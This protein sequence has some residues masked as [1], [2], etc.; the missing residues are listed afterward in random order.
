MHP[1]HEREVLNMTLAASGNETHRDKKR[2]ALLRSGGAT[3]LRIRAA[4][5]TLAHGGKKGE[6]FHSSTMVAVVPARKSNKGYVLVRVF[7]TRRGISMIRG[8]AKMRDSKAGLQ[9]FFNNHPARVRRAGF[10]RKR[11]SVQTGGH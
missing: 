5:T 6:Q 9:P 1:F 10:F 11:P 3:L 8:Q 7:F 2:A 4:G